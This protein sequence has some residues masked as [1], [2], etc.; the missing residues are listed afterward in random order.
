MADTFDLYNQELNRLNQEIESNPLLKAVYDQARRDTSSVYRNNS[1]P[2][3]IEAYERRNEINRNDP[4]FQNRVKAKLDQ[5]IDKRLTDPNVIF[6]AISNDP[7]LDAAFPTHIDK[8]DALKQV[9]ESVLDAQNELNAL[10]GYNIED[11]G[12]I[13]DTL[14]AVGSGLLNTAVSPYYAYKKHDIVNKLDNLPLNQLEGINKKLLTA[15]Q[16]QDKV[17][18]AKERMYSNDLSTRTRA[19]QELQYY[20]GTLDNLALTDEEQQIWDRYGKEYSSLKMEL[21]QVNADKS[22]LLGSRNISTDEARVLMDQYRRREEYKRQGIDP[23]LGDHVFDAIKDATSSFGAVGRS[24]GNVLSSAIPFMIPVVGGAL[25]VASF[26]STAMEYATDLME[27]H[28]RKY[29]ELPTE[30]QLKAA[31]Y[32]ALAAGIDYYGSKGLVKGYGGVAGQFFR[33]IG[34]TDAERFASEGAK[35]LAQK[36]E[37]TLKGL[38]QGSIARATITDITDFVSKELPN[39]S[40]KEFDSV[41]KDLKGTLDKEIYKE[42]LGTKAKK[43]IA[44][45]PE[46]I[47]RK[48][49]EAPIKTVEAV[50]KVAK[51]V[52]TGNKYLHEHF[53][54]GVQ[55]MAK[56]G[57]GLASENVG[58]ALVKIVAAEGTNAPDKLKGYVKDMKKYF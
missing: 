58:S 44:S 10:K 33:G 2:Q 32:G 25:G 30:E 37:S 28:L 29:N 34:K 47:M 8:F 43:A 4:E 14:G 22:D 24:L 5:L 51:G 55:D 39:L 20:K 12:F 36:W 53:D 1:V 19:L 49:L 27:D 35:F 6:A 42:T 40:K 21:D 57:L 16:I 54:A 9:Q 7:D 52:K 26:G 17:D 45:L 46:G 31:L 50:G 56:A 13:R 11:K 23:S 48:T 41:I 18:E 38:P 3:D 15:S